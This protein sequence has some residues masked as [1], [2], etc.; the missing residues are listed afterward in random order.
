M[1]AV[2]DVTLVDVLVVMVSK[3]TDVVLVV[4]KLADVVLV[5]AKLADVVPVDVLVLVL[6]DPADVLARDELSRISSVPTVTAM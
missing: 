5:D 1:S 2:L 3:L 6:V 4:V